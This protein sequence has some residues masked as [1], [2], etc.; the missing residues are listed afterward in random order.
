M[1]FKKIF[2]IISFFSY[3]SSF[4]LLAQEKKVYSMPGS[5]ISPEKDTYWEIEEVYIYDADVQVKVN[6]DRFPK[7]INSS[8]TLYMPTW[9]AEEELLDF[10]S[11]NYSYVF[12]I[13]EKKIINE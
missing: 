8:D 2:L 11:M 13:N 1:D 7:K 9:I 10:E 4:S 6:I 3:L 12:I 5:Y